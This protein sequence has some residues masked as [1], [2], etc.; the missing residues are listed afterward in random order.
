M[1]AQVKTGKHFRIALFH[2][3]ILFLTKNEKGVKL[4]HKYDLCSKSDPVVL[5]VKARESTNK[6]EFEIEELDQS[7]L[8]DNNKTNAKSHLEFTVIKKYTTDSEEALASEWV[9]KINTT[10]EKFKE[11][12]KKRLP[13]PIPKQETDDERK[14]REAMERRKVM[15]VM[16]RSPGMMRNHTLNS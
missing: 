11:I 7:E 16:M 12:Q 6:G 15:T 1:A 4:E 5:L 14:E 8:S 10:V 9:N 3:I 13:I 2:D